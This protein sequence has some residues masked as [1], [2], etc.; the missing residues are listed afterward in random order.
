MFG[1][2][3]FGDSIASG[4]GESPN[5]GWA[6]RLKKYFEP[7]GFHNCL[8]N[9]SI[10]GD[11]STDLL[12]RFETE[13]KARV[14]YFYPKDKFII[15]I[16][17]GLNDSRGINSPNKL[18]TKP[19]LF[20]NN[21]GKIIKIAKKYTKHIAVVGLTP[22]D[23]KLTNPFETTYLTNKRVKECNQILK[24]SAKKEKVKFIELFSKIAKMNY[25]KL[26]VDGLHPN[27]KGYEEI[28]KIIVSSIF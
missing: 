1:I 9:L 6:G 13:T 14:K 5:I 23:E 15:L 8:F 26:L 22:V 16:A 20:R 17:V 4:R 18:Q 3:V 25:Q 11:T 2:L 19:D 12:K 7:R 24:E 10:P 28:Y 27:K 21:I